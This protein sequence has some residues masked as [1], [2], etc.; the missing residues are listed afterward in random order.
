MNQGLRTIA[1]SYLFNAFFAG[2]K[3]SFKREVELKSPVP[4]TNFDGLESVESS[5]NLQGQFVKL[6]DEQVP[7]LGAEGIIEEVPALEVYV[8]LI[9]YS[10]NAR[11]P[12]KR[13][14][15][16]RETFDT[17]GLRKRGG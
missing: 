15:R 8:I 12:H 2:C 13:W 10:G 7:C 14:R 1:A 3:M 4:G 17:Q 5:G 11:Y 9:H 16:H 6:T